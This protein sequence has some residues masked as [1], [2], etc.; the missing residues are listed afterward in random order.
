MF[1]QPALLHPALTTSP[2]AAAMIGV[3]HDAPMSR[4]AWNALPP[5]TG[6]VRYPN[7][8]VIGPCTGQMKVLV[9]VPVL[10]LLPPLPVSL[11]PLS[12]GAGLSAA[13]ACCAS[14]AMWSDSSWSA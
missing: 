2:A 10:V 13:A 14:A 4:P 1:A 7:G 3:P 9:P 6:S 12:L 5:V 8:L 11:L